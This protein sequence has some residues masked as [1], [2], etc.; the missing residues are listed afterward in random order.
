MVNVL[1]KEQFAVKFFKHLKD[2]H[3]G[4]R[5]YIC[6][7]NVNFVLFFSRLDQAISNTVGLY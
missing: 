7:C 4:T 2:C 6:V 5:Q 3:I 1:Q